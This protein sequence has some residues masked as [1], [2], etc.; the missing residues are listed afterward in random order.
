M[1]VDVLTKDHGRLGLVARSAR[2][3]RSPWRG[4]IEPFMPLSFSF[5]QTGEM[6][7]VRDIE[8]NGDRVMLQ[9]K[10]LWC[11]LYVNELILYLI[12][13]GEAMEGLYDAYQALLKHLMVPELLSPSLRRFEW[14][15]LTA[16]GV[17]PSLCD[18]AHQQRAIDA[19]VLYRLEPEEGFVPADGAKG[20]VVRGEAIL[21]LANPSSEPSDAEIPKQARSIT[22]C[23]I[24]HQLN[25]RTLK[26]RE[27]MRALQ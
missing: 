6:G 21:W 18:E 17:A 16:L 13:R 8:P 12:D 23:L 1:L 5:V 3:E 9:G 11:G 4:L 7:T 26:T 22:R 19:N 15:L 24:D 14:H 10:A 2:S 27:M 20:L 25:G